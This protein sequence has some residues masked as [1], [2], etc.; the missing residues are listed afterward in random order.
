MLDA[1]DVTAAHVLAEAAPQATILVFR[2]GP[3]DV[4]LRGVFTALA[5]QQ[6]HGEC[7]ALSRC[8]ANLLCVEPIRQGSGRLA[9][10]S[11]GRPRDRWP[12]AR[13][14]RPVAAAAWEP[15]VRP[16]GCVL[17]SDPGLN[18]TGTRR[19]ETMSC[20]RYPKF[21]QRG[22]GR[23]T[24]WYK[25]PFV[26][27]KTHVTATDSRCTRRHPSCSGKRFLRCTL[28]LH[29]ARILGGADTFPKDSRLA[30]IHSA[31][32]QRFVSEEPDCVAGQVP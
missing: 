31:L 27:E 16:G 7:V 22:P 26:S 8:P 19:R 10:R 9:A 12:D 2:P 1:E 17:A 18:R 21:Q 24:V 11:G 20:S 32:R 14:A 4:D 6:T 28:V 3:D 25:P 29:A 5:E 30:S 13:D 15:L 23:F